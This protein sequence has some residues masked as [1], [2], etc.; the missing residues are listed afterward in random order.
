MTIKAGGNTTHSHNDI[1]SFVIGLGSVQ[2]VGDPGGPGHYTEATF[3]PHRLDSELLNSFGHPVPEVGGHLQLDATKVKAN[4]LS[5]S[6]SAREDRIVIDMTPAYDV[7]ELK[8]L[9]RTLVHR[10]D[11][12][13]TI[14]ITDEFN[15]K[16]ETTV[17]ESLPT[18]GIWQKVDDRTLLFTCW[19]EGVSVRDFRLKHPNQ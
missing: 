19:R 9:R 13:G 3:G 4:V 2:A 6:L 1:G 12:D 15:F 5:H 11:G 18:H 8:R 10:R 14:E 17:I 16:K 7:A